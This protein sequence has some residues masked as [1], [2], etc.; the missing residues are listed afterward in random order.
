M[1]DQLLDSEVQDTKSGPTEE[2]HKLIA[3]VIGLFLQEELSKNTVL[4]RLIDLGYPEE[5][6]NQVIEIAAKEVNV[7]LHRK[8]IRNIIVGGIFLVLGT[9]F[10][11]AH[12]G[13]IFY[14]AII[15]GGVQCIQGLIGLGKK[16]E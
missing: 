8:A 12:I 11:L 5:L 3:F 15:F 1:N 2:V 16:I 7:T 6:A 9:V 4:K 14:G 10:T 13:I